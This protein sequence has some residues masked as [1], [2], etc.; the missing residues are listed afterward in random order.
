VQLLQAQLSTI[1]R[2]Q[3]PQRITIVIRASLEICALPDFASANLD[4]VN[5][6]RVPFNRKREHLLPDKPCEQHHIDALASRHSV[7]NNE[8]CRVARAARVIFENSE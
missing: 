7:R 1:S 6:Q 3:S 8:Q 5:N 4:K 2:S